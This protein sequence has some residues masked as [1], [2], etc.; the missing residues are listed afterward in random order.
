[1][2]DVHKVKFYSEFEKVYF[3]ITCT[4]SSCNILSLSIVILCVIPC[5]A[6]LR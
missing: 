5:I 6:N 4:S 2:G 1:M 3:P